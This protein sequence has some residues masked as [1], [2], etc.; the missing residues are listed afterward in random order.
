MISVKMLIQMFISG[1]LVL[2]H[3]FDSSYQVLLPF[4]AGIAVTYASSFLSQYVYWMCRSAS[5]EM[6]FQ[7]SLG[8]CWEPEY[9]IWLPALVATCVKIIVLSASLGNFET[10][11]LSI[12][13]V[14]LVQLFMVATKWWM[15]IELEYIVSGIMLVWVSFT[16]NVTCDLNERNNIVK[17]LKEF[18]FTSRHNLDESKLKYILMKTNIHEQKLNNFNLHIWTI[19][20]TKEMTDIATSAIVAFTLV[21]I[22]SK[23]ILYFAT[24]S[25]PDEIQILQW[26]VTVVV[27]SCFNPIILLGITF[28]FGKLSE[29]LVFLINAFLG[30]AQPTFDAF[31][32]KVEVFFA[33]LC[34]ESGLMTIDERTRERCLEV[35][36]A[37]TLFNVVSHSLSRVKNEIVA[38][39]NGG[40]QSNIKQYL[41]FIIVFIVLAIGPS[42]CVFRL[43]TRLQTSVWPFYI[44]IGNFELH[45]EMIF[46]VIEFLLVQATWWFAE[47]F[48]IINNILNYVRFVGSSSLL[49]ASYVRCYYILMSPFFTAFFWLRFVLNLVMF[50][51][52]TFRICYIGWAKYKISRELIDGIRNL[53]GYKPSPDNSECSVCYTS[54]CLGKQLPCGHIFHQ[55]CVERWFQVRTTCPFCNSQVPITRHVLTVNGLVPAN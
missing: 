6:C 1:L 44:A 10:P 5:E 36:I 7:E 50:G 3:K 2:H 48:H 33:V 21:I 26:L 20:L 15:S 9:S 14:V 43:C 41:R 30:V 22:F 49:F 17:Q 55:E 29:L 51:I 23:F 19:K 42:F 45:I 40:G 47:K 12:A 18:Q 13:I 53:P 31:K 46:L 35:V 27:E 8:S 32:Y 34:I 11:N 52:N 4:Y 25:T 28:L 38:L 16:I 39:A 37:M 24:R 54:I